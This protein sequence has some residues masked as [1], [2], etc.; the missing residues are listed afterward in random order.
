MMHDIWLGVLDITKVIIHHM[1]GGREHG[2]ETL[3]SSA[4]TPLAFETYRYV[5]RSGTN[6]RIVSKEQQNLQGDR[7][8]L[9]TS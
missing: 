9:Y 6:G 7:I 1:G 8:F 4:Q 5:V 2:D 3:L